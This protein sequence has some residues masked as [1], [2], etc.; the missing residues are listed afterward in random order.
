MNNWSETFI[1]IEYG[2]GIKR[3]GI[4]DQMNHEHFEVL[5][6]EVVFVRTSDDQNL[7]HRFAF[8]SSSQTVKNNKG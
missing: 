5:F 8:R 6:V 3:E 7:S 1:R 2:G 4:E